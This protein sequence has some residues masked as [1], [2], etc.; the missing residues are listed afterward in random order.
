MLFPDKL[1]HHKPQ[2]DWNLDGFDHTKAMMTIVMIMIE[3]MMMLT[4]EMVV[5]MM[6]TIMTMI[7]IKVDRHVSLGNGYVRT[8]ALTL[9]HPHTE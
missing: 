4:S 3:S 2:I 7:T 1:V 9:D 6:I 8:S 5:I